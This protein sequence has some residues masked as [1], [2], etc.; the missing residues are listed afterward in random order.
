MV[1]ANM[2]NSDQTV[3]IPAEYLQSD[4]SLLCLYCF[5]NLNGYTSMHFCNYH[6]GE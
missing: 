5:L 2:E 4:Q 6:K 1:D 3:D